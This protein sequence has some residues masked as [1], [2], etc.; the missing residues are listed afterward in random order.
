MYLD[1]RTANPIGRWTDGP[2]PM[3]V[4]PEKLLREE[5]EQLMSHRRGSHPGDFRERA[6]LEGDRPEH[7]G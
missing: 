5:L 6:A 4:V 3:L 7:P 1:Q 2:L